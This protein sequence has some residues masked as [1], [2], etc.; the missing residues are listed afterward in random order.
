[1]TLLTVFY[2]AVGLLAFCLFGLYLDWR[3]RRRQRL[4]MQ[5]FYR[6]IGR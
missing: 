3:E 1:M 6:G 4:A 2:I 5:R